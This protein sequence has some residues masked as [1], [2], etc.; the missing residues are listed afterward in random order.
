MENKENGQILRSVAFFLVLVITIPVLFLSCLCGKSAQNNS[1]EQSSTKR[2]TATQDSARQQEKKLLE[3]WA[4]DSTYKQDSTVVY[5]KGDTVRTEHWRLLVRN[6]TKK[7]S[8]V[9]TLVKEVTK[10]RVD[11][12]EVTKYVNRY[13]T[14]EVE[15]QLTK[16]QKARLFIGDCTILMLVV[17]LVAQIRKR[18][19]N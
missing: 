9:D 18:L 13:Q 4:S 5:I 19:V 11:T 8:R 16:W 1:I 3:T 14:K 7:E 10:L 12:L 6:T 15:R 17:L 2:V